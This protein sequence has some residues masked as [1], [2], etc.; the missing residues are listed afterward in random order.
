MIKKNKESHSKEYHKK[1][2][3]IWYLNNKEKKNE[4]SRKWY[5]N[6][7]EKFREYQREYSKKYYKENK[8]YILENHKEYR[9]KYYQENKEKILAIHKIWIEENKE[10]ILKYMR[11]YWKKNKE[12]LKRYNK[13]YRKTE[14]GKISYQRG[15]SK[16]QIREKEIVNTL[17]VQEWKDILRQHNF[18]CAYCGKDLLDRP[19]RD[20]IISISKGGN[21]TKDNVVPTCKS[22][23][24]KKGNK[25]FLNKILILNPI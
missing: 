4:S 5:R 10:Y 11:E 9:R 20:H 19:E 21:N 14:N 2:F 24:A 23:N 12:K 17:T 13:E 16:R 6:N 8:E 7:L 22:C 18:K 25:V 3:E 15:Q 1:Y